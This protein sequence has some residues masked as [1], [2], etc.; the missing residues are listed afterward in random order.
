M[1]RGFRT[2]GVG[3]EI[4]LASKVANA[5]SFVFAFCSLGCQIKTGS[6]YNKFN[7]GV[8]VLLCKE[9]PAETSS[10]KTGRKGDIFG[11]NKFRSRNG[12]T[13]P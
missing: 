8:A 2:C 12:N 7:S 1:G 9:Q 13:F 5:V 3:L 4:F 6:F 11:G 10:V